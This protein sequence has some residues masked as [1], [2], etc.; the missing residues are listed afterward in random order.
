MNDPAMGWP[1]AFATVGTVLVIAWFWLSM[2]K[3]D[4][5]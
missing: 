4:D 1:E 5:L 3:R 2:A